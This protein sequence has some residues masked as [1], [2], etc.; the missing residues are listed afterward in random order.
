MTNPASEAGDTL[1]EVIISALLVGLIAVGTFSGLDSTTKATAL[2]RS[3]SQADALAEQDEERLRALPINM[4]AALESHPET[5]TITVGNTIY[6]VE[7]GASYIADT[8][9]TESCNS[10]SPEADY[11]QTTSKVT[12][13]S[14]GASKPVEETGVISPPPGANLIVQVTESGTALPKATVTVTELEPKSWTHTLETSSKGCAIFPLPEG[15]EYAIN[16]HKSGYVTPNGYD[17]TNEDEKDTQKV[18]I[19]AES[20]AKEGYYLGLAGKLQVKFIP[21]EGETFTVFNTGITSYKNLGNS[22]HQASFA[23][24]GT[25]HTYATQVETPAELYPFTTHYTIYAGECE[26]NKPP[27][28]REEN[29]VIVHPGAT[30]AATLSLPP[31]TLR[32]YKGHTAAEGLLKGATVT[33]TDTDPGCNNFKRTFETTELG[34]I[35]PAG[36][37]YGTYK[38]CVSG[39]AGTPAKLRR[40]EKPEITITTSTGAEET[41]YLGEKPETS[42]PCS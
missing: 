33:I 24:F 35:A 13:S 25:E 18:Y 31:M 12:W 32:V 26:A 19:T 36:L 14:L 5:S 22:P 40:Y 10:S 16:V 17:N 42:E 39:V 38:L 41:V 28:L 23:W 6:T 11:L 8:T 9:A 37:P 34:G 15:G 3:R 21:S 7:S 20:T 2:Q 4:L 30:T 1:I 29:E 27:T